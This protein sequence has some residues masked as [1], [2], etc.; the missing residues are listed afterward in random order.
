MLYE[1]RINDVVE[2]LLSHI[3]WASGS[4]LV[5]DGI[6]ATMSERKNRKAKVM[7]IE[8]EEDILTLYRD[9]LSS[10]TSCCFLLPQCKWHYNKFRKK[11]TWHLSD[12]LCTGRKE[13]WNWCCNRNPKEEP[14]N[15][16][17]FPDCIWVYAKGVTQT[18]YTWREKYTSFN[19]TC[20]IT[21]TR[22][23]H[24]QYPKLKN[25]Y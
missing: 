25:H 17:P 20:E 15:A 1:S 11:W 7:I 4:H 22:R 10:G 24:L 23:F 9:Y 18:S 2:P 8:D 6:E 21:W 19:E 5:Y 3:M 12:R 14:I 16:C 13:Q